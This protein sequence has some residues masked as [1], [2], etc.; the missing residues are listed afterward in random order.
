VIRGSP[1]FLVLSHLWWGRVQLLLGIH[2]TL[3]WN[4]V[5]QLIW[6]WLLHILLWGLLRGKRC[7]GMRS[8]HKFF[9]PFK[10]GNLGAMVSIMAILTAK[11]TREVCPEVIVV[12]LP[13][14]FIVVSPLGILVPLVLVSPNR[15]VLLGVVFPW[16]W[17]IIVSI[18]SFP[19]GIIR[20]MG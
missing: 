10:V 17:I 6:G 16:S 14:A 12:V 15:L 5:L 11:G 18:F 20:L 3:V 2:H 1:R 7:W 8:V 4:R 13:L 9:H 19:F